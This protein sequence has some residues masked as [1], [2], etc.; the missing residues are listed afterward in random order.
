MAL[1]DTPRRCRRGAPQATPGRHHGELDDLAGRLADLLDTRVSISLGRTKGRL[2]VDFASVEDLNR[3]L[4]ILAPE[5]R[6]MF[7]KV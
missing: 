3:I 7:Q 1:S 2:S 4:E 5:E 6:G